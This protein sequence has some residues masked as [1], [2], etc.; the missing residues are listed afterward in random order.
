MSLCWINMNLS[1]TSFISPSYCFTRTTDCLSPSSIILPTSYSNRNSL[2]I[3]FNS[4]SC[5]T[6]NANITMNTASLS[7]SQNQISSNTQSIRS[8]F[9]SK[10]FPPGIT[11]FNIEEC[12]VKLSN[13]LHGSRGNNTINRVTEAIRKF[14][15]GEQF[16]RLCIQRRAMLQS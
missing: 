5:C 8:Y 2:H 14:A 6:Q 3:Q 7:I 1:I 15:N 11:S 16:N 4:C 10:T 13:K 9:I 12:T